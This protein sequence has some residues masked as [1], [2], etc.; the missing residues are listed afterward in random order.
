MSDF[1]QVTKDVDMYLT[2][3]WT[4]RTDAERSDW[5]QS[6]CSIELIYCVLLTV[7]ATCHQNHT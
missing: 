7:Q 6:D 4:S 1:R 5:V 2:F 3:W